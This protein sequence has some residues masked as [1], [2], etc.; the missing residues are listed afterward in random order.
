MTV[1]LVAI[2]ILVFS[3]LA[4]I[5]FTNRPRVATVPVPAHAWVLLGRWVIP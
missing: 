3:G 4:P 5:L 2:A 1:L